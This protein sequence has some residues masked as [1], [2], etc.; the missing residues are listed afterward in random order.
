MAIHQCRPR[1]CLKLVRARTA[2]EA[3]PAITA[4]EMLIRSFGGIHYSFAM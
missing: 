4:E 3:I 2:K 1:S